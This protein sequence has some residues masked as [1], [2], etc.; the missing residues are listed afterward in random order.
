M[1]FLSNFSLSSMVCQPSCDVLQWVCDTEMAVQSRPTRKF[2][3]KAL[4]L[5]QKHTT[6]SSKIPSE[7]YPIWSENN[8]KRVGR[9]VPLNPGPKTP[10]PDEREEKWIQTWRMKK[11]QATPHS[12]HPRFPSSYC[13]SFWRSTHKLYTSNALAVPKRESEEK[14]TQNLNM[15]IIFA[16]ATSVAGTI[17]MM[18]KDICSLAHPYSVTHRQAPLMFLRKISSPIGRRMLRESHSLFFWGSM[19]TLFCTPDCDNKQ[20]NQED[21]SERYLILDPHGNECTSP[22]LSMLKRAKAGPTKSWHCFQVC[23]LPLYILAL[24][25]VPLIPRLLIKLCTQANTLSPLSGSRLP[26]ALP[27]A[28]MCALCTSRYHRKMVS[29]QKELTKYFPE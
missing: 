25:L 2:T 27:A 24:P 9:H 22:S 28:K 15:K 13:W 17:L 21:A 3:S 10:T 8:R 6:T 7:P 5:G 1:T 19:C 14:Q 29:V 11:V 16:K 4:I 26:S 12:F 18:G 23:S 20:T